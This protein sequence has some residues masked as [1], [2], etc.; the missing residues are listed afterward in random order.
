MR[1]SFVASAGFRGHVGSLVPMKFKF[2]W[3]LAGMVAAVALAWAFPGPGSHDGWLHPHV[4]NKV[5]VA[6]IFFLNGAGLSFA[7]LKHGVSRWK[8]HMVV[9]AA[10]FGLFPLVGWVVFGF[11]ADALPATLGLGFFFLCALPSTVSSSVAMT[12]AARGNVPA[13]VFNATLSSLL[14]VFLTPLWVGLVLGATNAGG[15][16]VGGVILDLVTWL[17]VP[18]AL[19]QA[20]RPLIAEWVARHKKGVHMVDRCTILLIIYTSFCDSVSGGVWRGQGWV[21][22]LVAL[23]GSAVLFAVVCAVIDA[24]CRR[25]GFPVEDRIAAVFCGSKKTIASGV[26]MAQLIFAGDP[27]LGVILLPLLIYHPLQLVI[28]GVMAGRWARR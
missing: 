21:A 2:D 5:G 24:V 11:G 22:V 10:T 26:P 15:S 3:F 12:S 13:A 28:C 7:A 19:G 23:V 17:L 4:L 18:L 14:G 16:S 9:Q 27:R 8:L 20:S 1:K 25:L 6:L